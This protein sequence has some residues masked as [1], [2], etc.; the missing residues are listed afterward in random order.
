MWQE[1]RR[2]TDRIRKESFFVTEGSQW[3]NHL[4]RKNTEQVGRAALMPFSRSCRS[5]CVCAQMMWH[6]IVLAPKRFY[7]RFD[8]TTPGATFG[9]CRAIPSRG[10]R[11]DGGDQEGSLLFYHENPNRGSPLSPHTR[12]SFRKQ[13]PSAKIRK[14]TTEMACEVHSK[15]LGRANLRGW[16]CAVRSLCR[17]RRMS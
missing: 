17:C 4:R 3:H 13:T 5:T 8:R 9:A 11:R 2:G 12:V 6:H 14:Q 1:T 7:R 15:G 16:G 10:T